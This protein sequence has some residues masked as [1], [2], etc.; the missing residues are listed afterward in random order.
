MCL[1]DQEPTKKATEYE[2]STEIRVCVHM[3]NATLLSQLLGRAPVVLTRASLRA[4]TATECN[5]AS[6]AHSMRPV[7]APWD[8]GLMIRAFV[9]EH[10]ATT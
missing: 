9:A 1:F 4:S 2:K 8:M 10:F 6:V 3:S 5:G 7:F